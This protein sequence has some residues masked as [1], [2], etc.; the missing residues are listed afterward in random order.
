MIIVHVIGGLGNQLFQ[1]AFG[2]ALSQSKNESLILDVSSFEAYQRA[3]ELDLF[4][5]DATI[6]T[7]DELQNLIPKSHIYIEPQFNF[8]KEVFSLRDV[9]YF[10][11]YWQSEKYF[12]KYRED[13]LKK[14]TPRDEIQKH[15]KS[16]LKLI[17]ETESVSL[18][19]RRGDYVTNALTNSVH[20]T[21]SLDYYKKA[22]S[23]LEEK[24][25]NP[26]FYI[27]S[28][29]LD[30][31]KNNITF[32]KN[33]TFVELVEEVPDYDEMLLMS[34]CNHNIIANSS[35]SWWGAWLNQNNNKIVIAPKR[36]FLDTSLNTI[37]LIPESWIHI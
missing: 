34:R 9:R 32:I 7:Q 3:Y 23:A 21:C 26:H 11:G 20:G 29:D 22:V 14:I 37:D 25:N 1:Y 10:K 15:S 36:W 17:T 5:I 33:I 28:D 12:V 2:Y 8:N 18:H 16:Y 6:A 13:I 19:I 4:N 30:W 31:A 35:F 24:T 27:F